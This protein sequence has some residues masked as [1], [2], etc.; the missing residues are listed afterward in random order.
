M[1]SSME[2]NDLREDSC[3]R[4]SDLSVERISVCNG[5]KKLAEHDIHCLPY[6]DSNAS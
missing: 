4:I 2:L 1:A 3:F 6:S 5:I